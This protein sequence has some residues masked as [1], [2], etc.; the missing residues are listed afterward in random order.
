MA[1]W[2]GMKITAATSPGPVR[3]TAGAA[4]NTLTDHHLDGCLIGKRGQTS[5]DWEA[6]KSLAA[7]QPAAG[8]SGQTVYLINGIMTD[9]QLHSRDMQKLADVTGNSV[10]GIHNSTRGLVRDLAQCLGDKLG[11]EMANNRAVDTTE[12][13]VHSALERGEPLELVAHSQGALVASRALNRVR[14][15]LLEQG[16]TAAEAE[17]QLAR[18]HLTTVGGASYT[19]PRGPAYSHVVNTLDAVAMLSGVGIAGPLSG[20]GSQIQH[21]HEFHSPHDLPTG[22]DGIGNLFARVVDRAVHGPQD[23]YFPKLGK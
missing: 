21:F 1:E 10:I 22:A 12:Q 3:P 2:G 7:M 5:S 6:S 20:I 13:V 19:F 4:L 23:V 16:H 15:Q 9:V 17:G 14:T 18:V 11:L 8:G